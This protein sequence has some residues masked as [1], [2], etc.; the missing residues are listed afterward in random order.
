MNTIQKTIDELSEALNKIN[1]ISITVMEQKDFTKLLAWVYG[2]LNNYKIKRKSSSDSLDVLK[3][4][5]QMLDN[6]I[7]CHIKNNL[8][9]NHETVRFH[10]EIVKLLLIIARIDFNVDESSYR[11]AQEIKMFLRALQASGITPIKHQKRIF[12]SR[13]TNIN[14]EDSLDNEALKFASENIEKYSIFVFKMVE[15]NEYIRNNL[16]EEPTASYFAIYSRIK[17]LTTSFNILPS[18]QTSPNI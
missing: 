4:T 16:T 17:S 7:I 9:A 18:E 13:W 3:L 1:D 14:T 15:E 11:E 10:D 8:I 5:S 12:N 2:V 6:I